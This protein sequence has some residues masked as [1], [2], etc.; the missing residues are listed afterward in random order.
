MVIPP[1]VSATSDSYHLDRLYRVCRLCFF[2]V[3]IAKNKA[4]ANPP[5]SLVCTRAL[6][7]YQIDFNLEVTNLRLP[8]VLCPTCQTRLSDFVTQKVDYSTWIEQKRFLVDAMHTNEDHLSTRSSKFC[9]D[10]RRCL[11]CKIASSPKSNALERAHSVL[12]KPGRPLEQ[13]PPKLICSKC[14]TPADR[15][16]DLL[17]ERVKKRPHCSAEAGEGFAERIDARGYTDKFLVRRLNDE[18]SQSLANNEVVSL[19]SRTDSHHYLGL[20]S[21]TGGKLG[22]SGGIFPIAD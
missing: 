16:D 12:P 21:F 22:R 3:P 11:V 10:Q 14:S 20:S 1:E 18:F 9:S 19:G 2:R 6:E 8:K 17:C 5:T 13:S 7:Y 4:R 15:H